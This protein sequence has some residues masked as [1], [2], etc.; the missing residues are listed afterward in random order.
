MIGRRSTAKYPPPAQLAWFCYRFAVAFKAGIPV[1]DAVHLVAQDDE[2]FGD[3]LARIS[4]DIQA[5]I[6]FHQALSNQG[7]FPPYLVGMVKVGERTGTL[8][9]VMESLAAHYE[10]E[11]YLRHELRDA[12]TYPLILV[13]MVAAVVLVITSKILPVFGGILSDA[14][15]HMPAVAT[16][17]M[18]L[19]I[20]LLNKLG[21]LVGIPLA[22]GMVFW[23]WKATA[24]GKE[25]I[26][27]FKART[28]LL[29]GL[30]SKVYM[31]RISTVMW[32]ALESGLDVASALEMAAQVVGNG[33]V[34]RQLDRS[35]QLIQQGMD[36]VQ[37]FDAAGIF[38]STFV[39]MVR[40]GHKTGELPSMAQKL[41]GLYQ[42]Q[43]YRTLQ[44][45]VS[46]IEPALVSVLSV[47]M[48]IVLIAV[49]LPLISIITK[50]G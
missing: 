28:G 18:H 43:V 44:S 14:G 3:H 41:A 33:Y 40:I 32:Y 7:I 12:L 1:A 11:D 16:A 45:T 8:D 17:L 36:L 4:H 6:G 37:S 27:R 13:I 47:V 29:D 34:A 48:G 9:K 15:V 23:A 26:D 24:S 2:Y 38:P 5:G 46:R 49:V 42:E 39:N 19:G 10:H 30:F 25:A 22:G 21:W 35:R 31:A 20:F 50:I